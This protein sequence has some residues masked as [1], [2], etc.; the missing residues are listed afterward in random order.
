MNVKSVQAVRT[1]KNAPVPKGTS[2]CTFRKVFW[3]SARNPMR[4]SVERESES[5]TGD[6]FT[7]YGI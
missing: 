5:K 7:M 2:V 4:I 1:K 6:T 3:K